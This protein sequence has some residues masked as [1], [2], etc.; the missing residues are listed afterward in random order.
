MKNPHERLKCVKQSFD[1]FMLDAMHL[2]EYTKANVQFW[3]VQR[4]PHAIRISTETYTCRILSNLQHFNI[5]DLISF[6]RKINFLWNT[7]IL[8]RRMKRMYIEHKQTCYISMFMDEIHWN[9]HIHMYMYIVV[10]K[11]H[12]KFCGSSH[13]PVKS[14]SKWMIIFFSL[15]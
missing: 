15:C 12:Y 8:L 4:S 11:S 6:S 1:T 9:S 7:F 2:Q 13:N 10:V 5:P 3:S 14:F